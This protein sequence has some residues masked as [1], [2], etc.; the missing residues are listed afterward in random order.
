MIPDEPSYH[1]EKCGLVS[2]HLPG[3][4]YLPFGHFQVLLLLQIP[5]LGSPEP[6]LAMGER[7]HSTPV[8]SPEFGGCGLAVVWGQFL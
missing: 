2:L 4:C 7:Q 1:A 6:S 3:E 8:A 5:L